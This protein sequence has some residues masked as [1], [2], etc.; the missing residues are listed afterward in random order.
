MAKRTFKD[1]FQ[2]EK[3]PPLNS[4]LDLNCTRSRDV[5]SVVQ[6][7]RITTVRADN[8]MGMRRY[9]GKLDAI[10]GIESLSL[11]RCGITTGVKLTWERHTALKKIDLSSNSISSLGDSIKV[12]SA[13]EELIL[14]KNC[15]FK[16]LPEILGPPNLRRVDLSRNGIWRLPKPEE[17]LG[18]TSGITHLNLRRNLINF[19]YPNDRCPKISEPLNGLFAA[20]PSLESLNLAYNEIT[21]FPRAIDGAVAKHFTSLNLE[22]NGLKTLPDPDAMSPEE[23]EDF[24]YLSTVRDLNLYMNDLTWFPPAFLRLTPNLETLNLVDNDD[25]ANLD[26]LKRA[27][28]QSNI[29]VLWPEE[30][31]IPIPTA[32]SDC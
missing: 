18:R 19:P 2:G 27:V 26:D 13:L 12:L 3:P 17:L 20:M 31:A 25:I 8:I 29:H 23:L 24:R 32:K 5:E 4:V 21:R 6:R 9:W 28:A 10:E 30:I 16:I 1:A 11:T 7:G 15:S 14:H 22:A